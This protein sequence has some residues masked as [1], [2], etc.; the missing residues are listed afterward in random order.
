MRVLFIGY[1]GAQNYG[2]DAMLLNILNY[3]KVNNLEYK[4]LLLDKPKEA[5]VDLVSEDKL[6]SYVE[7]PRGKKY[8]QFI[9]DIKQFDYFFWIGG[10]CFT[11]TEGDG[12]FSYMLIAKIFRKKIGY[13]GIGVNYLYNKKRRNR[14]KFIL[15]HSNYV[16]LRDKVSLENINKMRI[17]NN[18]N[19]YVFSDLF[20][21]MLHQ[22]K[23]I[24]N[25]YIL[26]SLRFLTSIYDKSIENKTVEEIV[27]LITE[28]Y[29]K[30]RIIILPL[31][32]SLDNEINRNLYKK[33]KKY[34]IDCSIYENESFQTKNYLISHCNINITGRLHSAVLSEYLQK[35][36][37]VLNYDEKITTFLS[38]VGCEGDG[39]DIKNVDNEEMY[40]IL[41]EEKVPTQ[42]F[43]ELIDSS[44]EGINHFIRFLYEHE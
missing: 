22:Y 3:T 10:T 14:A 19:I 33:L 7:K 23:A 42:G 43:Q 11:D 8:L 37:V 28:F 32:N 4:I 30:E 29:S 27:T 18:N 1:F 9:K 41:Q 34:G 38:T 36:T 2:D 24:N 25:Q 31:D 39:I 26:I 17:K 21:L 44:E 15:S 13:V 6:I 16:C 5:L 40:S 12:C 20:Y 35:K